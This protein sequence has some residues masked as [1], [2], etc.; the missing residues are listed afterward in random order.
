MYFAE[1]RQKP[2]LGEIYEKAR[3]DGKNA[4]ERERVRRLL[5]TEVDAD[6][7]NRD[8]CFLSVLV[9]YRNPSHGFFGVP[10]YVTKLL[11]EAGV[12]NSPETAQQVIDEQCEK[13]FEYLSF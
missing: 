3:V 12:I 1:K 5:A 9:R 11:I 10:L 2:T 7:A 8:G 6:R 13:T 4:D